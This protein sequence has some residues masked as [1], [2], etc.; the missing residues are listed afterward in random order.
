MQHL[1][2]HPKRQQHTSKAAKTAH[3]KTT[4]ACSTTKQQ[5]TI[6]TAARAAPNHIAAVAAAATTQHHVSATTAM[7]T[8]A[9]TAFTPAQ[10]MVHATPMNSAK[11]HITTKTLRLTS[12]RSIPTMTPTP[13]FSAAQITTL[14]RPAPSSAFAAVTT[15]PAATT[16]P[17]GAAQDVF[18]YLQQRQFSTTADAHSDDDHDHGAYEKKDAKCPEDVVMVNIVDRNQ[19]HHTIK[20]KVGDNVLELMRLHTERT[21]ENIWLEGSCEK[22]LACSTCHIVLDDKTYNL[23]QQIKEATEEEEDMLDMAACLTPTSRLGCQINLTKD[24]D[25]CTITLPKFSRNMYVD[26]HVPQPH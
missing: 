2:A 21:N 13:T 8:P 4:K 16:T 17:A 1:K 10:N 3:K 12:V 24:M 22:S 5:R 18:N 7:A 25:G 20:C 23:L 19:T 9:A 26:G 15:T 11:R 14:S 6:T